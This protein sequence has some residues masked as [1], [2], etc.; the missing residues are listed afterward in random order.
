MPQSGSLTGSTVKSMK[1]VS[2]KTGEVQDIMPKA[3][4]GIYAASKGNDLGVTVQMEKDG[5]AGELTVTITGFG[6]TVN[7]QLSKT[8]KGQMQ[9]S[10][11]E[12]SIE[13]G[14]LT[15][16]FKGYG[17]EKDAQINAELQAQVE[18][19]KSMIGMVCNQ[20][21]MM[22]MPMVNAVLAKTPCTKSLEVFQMPDIHFSY[23]LAEDPKATDDYMEVAFCG[24]TM[25]TEEMESYTPGDYNPDPLAMSGDAIEKM[26]YI[27][28]AEAMV[29]KMCQTLQSAGMLIKT[30]SQ[31]DKPEIIQRIKDHMKSVD[32]ALE[33]V[34]TDDAKMTCTIT[35]ETAPKVTMTAS[36]PNTLKVNLKLTMKHEI[37]SPSMPEPKIM[38]GT[39]DIE[40][41]IS[42]SIAATT[43]EDKVFPEYTGNIEITKMEWSNQ[44]GFDSENWQKAEAQEQAKQGIQKMLNGVIAK[45]AKVD[46]EN[47]DKLL[48][49]F[50]MGVHFDNMQA[51][52]LD[53]TMELS[54]DV[55][56]NMDKMLEYSPLNDMIKEGG[57]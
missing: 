42:H 33:A 26:F 27:W 51:T 17:D 54:S 23:C 43:P 16:T 30:V 31:D 39:A 35:S 48:P 41:S 10:M 28:E 14:E 46:Y 49:K 8:D 25:T 11:D 29:N 57:M 56:F 13:M 55:H 5:Q 44:V 20:L 47:Q 37:T 9:I 45:Y 34:L 53:K 15:A 22:V 52:Y 40:A 36:E 32:P 38:Q 21:K 6:M 12:C 3:P 1:F 2:V 50:L 4:S 24:A 7:Q 19:A 18:M